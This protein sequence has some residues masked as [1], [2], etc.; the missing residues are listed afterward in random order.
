MVKKNISNVSALYQKIGGLAAFEFL[1]L[2]PQV[3]FADNDV[4]YVEV[5]TDVS[6]TGMLE[7]IQGYFFGAI[8]AACVFMVL[9]G[10]FDLVTSGGDEKKLT[11]GKNRILYASVGLVVAALSTGIVSLIMSVAGVGGGE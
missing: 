2:C 10:A 5:R 3:L 9:W 1:F 7:K 4:P 6:I 11:S 8:I